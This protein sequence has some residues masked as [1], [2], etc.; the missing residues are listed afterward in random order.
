M[1][2]PETMERVREVFAETLKERYAGELEFDP[3]I[4]KATVDYY[5]DGDE[6]FKVFMVINGDIEQLDH[7][8]GAG[9]IGRVRDRLAAEGI[10]EFPSPY[11]M[12]KAEYLSFVKRGQF[13]AL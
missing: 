7:E 6:Y 3:I 2:T 13:D 1:I 5:G 12:G 10:S 8:W 9:L 4:V 11:F